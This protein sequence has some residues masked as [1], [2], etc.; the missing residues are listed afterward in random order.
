MVDVLD[1][2]LDQTHAPFGAA[3]VRAAN[4]DGVP[5]GVF[6]EQGENLLVQIGIF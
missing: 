2:L 5:L 1:S 3:G 6:V 4:L